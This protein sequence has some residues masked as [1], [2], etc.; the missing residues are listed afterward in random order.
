VS[1]DGALTVVTAG[2]IEIAVAR[3]VGTPLGE[4]PRLTGTI[5]D[6]G[7]ALDL[8]ALRSR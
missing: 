4:G 7:D 3:I 6:S 1:A 5:G 2:P 8:A